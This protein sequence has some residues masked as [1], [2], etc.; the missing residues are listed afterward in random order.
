MPPKSHIF[1][2][3]VFQILASTVAYYTPVNVEPGL[4]KG[5]YQQICDRYNGG[6]HCQKPLLKISFLP[7]LMSE[8]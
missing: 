5:A 6:C 7:F 3:R 8:L 4:G 2:V 1:L